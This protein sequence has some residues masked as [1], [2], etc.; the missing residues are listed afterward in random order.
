[1]RKLL[2]LFIC[3]SCILSVGCGGEPTINARNTKVVFKSFNRM[4]NYLPND[5]R[6]EFEIAFWTI[7]DSLGNSKEFLDTVDGKNVAEIIALG[8]EHFNQRK[9]EGIPAYD[10]YTS[11]DDMLTRVKAE[12]A[13][14]ALPKQKMTDRDRRNNL[15]YDPR[16]GGN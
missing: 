15:L 10:K 16:V 9:A 14:Q 2:T 6:L 13:A 11:W 7:R 5:E 3:L 8:Q 4:K 1:M 12:R